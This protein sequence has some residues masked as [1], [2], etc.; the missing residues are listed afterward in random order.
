[1]LLES[2]SLLEK[3]LLVLLQ[4]CSPS[5]NCMNGKSIDAVGRLVDRLVRLELERRSWM[6]GSYKL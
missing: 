1:M 2:K 5:R 3:V 4:E 6:S